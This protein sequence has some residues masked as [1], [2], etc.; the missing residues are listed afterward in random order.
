MVAQEASLHDETLNELGLSKQP[1]LEDKKLQRFADSET[2][3]TRAALEQHLRF[4]DSLHLLLGE[5]GAGKTVL[6]SQLIKHC[7]SS[8][9]PFV[10]KGGEDFMAKSFLHAVLQQLNPEAET[11]DASVDHYI[12]NLSPLFEQI[13]NDQYSVVLAVDDAHLAPLEEIAEL[14]DLTSQ[15]ES[16]SGK[17]A[18]LLLTGRPSLKQAISKIESQFEDLDL[19]YSTNIITPMDEARVR[20]YLT[21]RLNQAGFADAFPFT[22]KAISKIQRDSAGLPAKINSEATHYLNGVYRGTQAAAAGAKTAWLGG[23]NWPVIAVGAAALGAIGWG[24]SL[25]FGNDSDTRV[26]PVT[27]VAAIEQD[28]EPVVEPT[29][30]AAQPIVAENVAEETLLVPETEETVITP[31]EVITPSPTDLVAEVS[32]TPVANVSN[33]LSDTPVAD[34]APVVN[35]VVDEEIIETAAQTGTQLV[36]T[37][38]TLP[39]QEQSFQ[40]RTPDKNITERAAVTATP[41]VA[42][43]AD[44]VAEGV[45]IT[46]NDDTDAAA[47]AP[48]ESINVDTETDG[49]GSG[50]AV[51]T[52]NRAIENERWVLFQSPTKFTVQV[53]TSRE[54]GYIIDLAQ[55]MDV[56]DPIA[57]YPFLT[58]ESKNPVFGLLSGL[59]DTRSEAIAAVESMSADAKKFGTWIRPVADLQ[60]D[61]KR[62]Q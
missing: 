49:S 41:V 35:P 23:L 17:T 38:V 26:V 21:S 12:D 56:T 1:F 29:S 19:Q 53:A 33:V 54:R 45:E 55:T 50:I 62:R 44:T 20:E 32:E 2:Q 10:V 3:R 60:E 42:P 34:I 59:Y 15:F 22:D 13:N 25:F 16:E 37:G 6:L 4:G 14:V 52:P 48:E 58:T 8:I 46:F 51:T 18:R 40:T 5:D 57:I 39:Q 27:E 61:I 24:I 7:K 30:A 11:E 28:I 43:A 36:D 31:A 9:K 47:P